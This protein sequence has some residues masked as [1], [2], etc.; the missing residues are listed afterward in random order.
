MKDT[1]IP[2]NEKALQILKGEIVGIS[3][4]SKLIVD[5]SAY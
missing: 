1:I 4:S 2:E 3:L 5:L